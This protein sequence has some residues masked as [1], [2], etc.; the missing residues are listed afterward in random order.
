M[1]LS[2]SFPIHLKPRHEESSECTRCLSFIDV[3]LDST[4]DVGHQLGG[5]DGRCLE[6]SPRPRA[7]T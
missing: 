7:G 3:G 4:F 2:I 5:W 6:S 1:E